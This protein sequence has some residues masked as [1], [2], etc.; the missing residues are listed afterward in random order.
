LWTRRIT[1][2]PAILPRGGPIWARSRRREKKAFAQKELRERQ[3]A[4]GL[5][6]PQAPTASNAKCEYKT[7]EEEQEAREEA[8]TALIRL[9][10]A[11]LPILLERLSKIPDYRN[12][13]KIKHKLTVVLISGILVFVYQMASR[14][15]ANRTMSR[16]AFMESLRLIF[17]DLEELPHHD[18]LNRILS[19]IEVSQI[20]ETLIDLKT[21]TGADPYRHLSR[22]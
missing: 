10:R 4:S 1:G 17:P 19:G 6:A 2:A 22:G 12:P 18:T 5:V 20:E 8:A 13:K 21:R 3:K 9:L 7:V 14:R 16:P 15:E 11:K